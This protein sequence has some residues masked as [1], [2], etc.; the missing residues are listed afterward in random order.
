VGATQEGY[1]DVAFAVEPEAWRA[2][3]RYDEALFAI[4]Q[5]G[6]TPER[7]DPTYGRLPTAAVRL[8]LTLAA[9]EWA[10]DGGASSGTPPVVGRRH[11]A[12]AQE[13]AERWR[14]HAHGV[15][16]RALGDEADG[17]AAAA[18]ARLVRF[19]SRE[20]G[21]QRR[22]DLQ[23]GL[24]L[25]SAELDAAITAAGPRVRA[26]DERTRGQPARWVGLTD[27]PAGPADASDAP[28]DRRG[29]DGQTDHPSVGT[30]GTEGLHQDVD[31]PRESSSFVPATTQASAPQGAPPSPTAHTR[32]PAGD[33]A[34]GTRPVGGVQG[35]GHTDQGAHDR[36]HPDERH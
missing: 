34:Q 6:A 32:H 7:L 35:D 24:N 28:G 5:R 13:V 12:A 27:D 30:E 16:A 23:R 9:T 11:W 17:A 19:L 3:R 8:A 22:G 10:L 20:G 29:G 21:R 26:W 31:P 33:D 25:T 1:T 4:V 15:L 18:A 2:W 14:R 36:E